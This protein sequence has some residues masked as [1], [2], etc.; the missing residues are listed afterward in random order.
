MISNEYAIKLCLEHEVKRGNKIVKKE[1][2]VALRGEIYFV[3]FII[4]LE[5]DDVEPGVIFGRSFLRMTKAITDFGARTITIYHDIDLFLEDTEEEEK[6]M[7]DWG[8]FLDFNLDDIPVLGGEEL[9]LFVCKMGKSS[10][11]KKRAMENLNLFYQDIGTSS[12]TGR[13]LTQKE[14]AK[15]ALALRISQKFALLEEV[16]P[17]FETMAYHDKYKKVLNEIWKDKV[18]LDG[19]I[20]K[21]EEAI[22]RLEGRVNK[23]AL[24]DTGSDIN[25]IPYRIYEQL[26]REEMKKVD[27]GITMINHTQTEAMGILTNVLFNTPERFF[28]T[29]DGFCHQTFHAA[30]SDVMRNVESDSDDEEEYEIKRNKFRAPIYGLKPAPYLNCNDPAERSLAIQTVTNPFG[31][32]SVWKKVVSFLGSL[33]V[34]LKHVNWKPDYKGSY[35]K[36]EEAIGQLWEEMILKLDHRDPNALDNLKPWRRYCFYKF[37]LISYYRKVATMRRSLEIDDMLR[38]KLC[39]A[40]SN[41]EIFTFVAWIRA[42]NIKEPIYVELCHEFYSTYEFD[43][44]C[45]DDELQSKKI[46]KFRLDGRAY[47]LTLLE[48]AHR[49]RLYHADELE[50]DGFDV[51]F[52]GGLHSDDNFNAHDYWLSISREENLGLSRCHASTIR[53]PILR[54]IHK[55][56]TYGLCQ[57]TTRYDKIQKNDLWLLSMFDARHQ[58]GYANVAWLVVRWMKRKG[59]G[60]QRE[61]Q[62]CCGQFIM[63]IA[64]KARVLTDVVLRSLSALIYCRDLD[65]TTLRELIESEGRL[66]PKDPQ[67]GVPRVGIPR[68]PRASMYQGMFEH[69]SGVYSVPLQGA[70]NPPGYACW[71]IENPWKA[72]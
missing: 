3:K 57:R 18:E 36:E 19:M 32:I 45:A 64:R 4:N 53:N 35:T 60:T 31:K 17:V 62:I 69:M 43:E 41:E 67:S 21:E 54:V 50:E 15:E 23:N 27:R 29:F 2:I 1:L 24:A 9:P 44:V 47:N 68:P 56:I 7:D 49:L 30:R 48:F 34:P 13:H 52:Q 11:D 71:K 51:Y 12:S 65:T 46:I 72:N 58:N 59:A 8:Q 20:M 33:H 38:I 39:E 70:Y 37:I 16:R 66:I 55:M 25:T 26:G 42:F 10:R 63:K 40:K 6:S 28:S 61:S 22:K 5:E 14:A